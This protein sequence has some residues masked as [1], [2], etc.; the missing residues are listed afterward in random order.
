MIKKVCDNCGV[1][2]TTQNS[3]E[4]TN[5]EVAHLYWRIDLCES[6]FLHLS[7]EIEEIVGKY[8]SGEG[9]KND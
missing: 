3:F 7:S 4:G 1:E 2:L 5:I 8:E 6:C 9:E